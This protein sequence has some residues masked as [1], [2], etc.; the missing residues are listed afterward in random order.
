[1]TVLSERRAH[2]SGRTSAPGTRAAALLVLGP[3]L[4]IAGGRWGSYLGITGAPIFASDLLVGLGL[5]GM[6][7]GALRGTGPRYR[8]AAPW[9]L[10]VTIGAVLVLGLLRASALSVLTVED[11]LPFVYLLL[12]PFFAMAVRTLGAKRVITWVGTAAAIHLVWFVPAAFGVLPTVTVPVIFGIPVFT[13]RGDFDLV[14][15]GVAV[16]W[17][18]GYNDAPKA[19]RWIGALAGTAAILSAGSRAGLLAAVLIGLTVALYRQPWKNPRL[20]PL[21]VSAGLAGTAAIALFLLFS[22]GLPKWAVTLGRLFGQGDKALNAE[23]T[24]DARVQAWTDIW[25]YMNAETGRLW[26]GEGFGSS[27]I[28][29]SGALAHLSGDPSVREAHDFLISWLGLVG[30]TGAAI[31][32]LA[33]VGILLVGLVAAARNRE[34]VLAP[35][36]AAGLVLAGSMG[37]I[38]ES[39]FGY[40]TFV[41]MF[42]IAL[43]ARVVLVPRP[44]GVGPSDAS[45]PAG[46]GPVSGPGAAAL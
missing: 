22:P 31:A 40:Q 41:L 11:M 43:S 5:F 26:F 7:L 32:G 18:V 16:A 27:V 19:V 9:W 4:P 13:T 25:H 23:N 37:V 17:L 10:L 30:L 29:R 24:A 46:T 20:G 34:L 6:L 21:L 28:A 12:S 38:L 39:P 36:F 1:V 14:I 8:F 45:A 42:G 3:L 15:T 44:T 2:A 33:V 35:A